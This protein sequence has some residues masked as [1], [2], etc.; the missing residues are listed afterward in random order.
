MP[1]QAEIDR[2]RR[3]AQFLMGQQAPQGGQAGRFYVAPSPFSQ[4]ASA[5]QN[6]AGAFVG[7]QADKQQGELDQQKKDEMAKALMAM[8]TGA[9][10]ETMMASTNPASA[11]SGGNEFLVAQQ[12]ISSGVNPALVSEWL[13][14]Q[15]P[16]DPIKLGQGDRLINPTT[17]EP[18]VSGAP[19]QPKPTDDMREYE[20]AKSQGYP[21][22]FQDYMLEQ[23]KA[24]GTSV[25]VKSEGTIPTGFKAVRDEQGNLIRYEPVPGGPAAIEAE[26][27]ATAAENKN[28][29]ENRK[30]NVVLDEIDRAFAT[31][32]SPSLP[33]TG[34]IGNALKGV[35]GT[36]SHSLANNLTTIKSNIGFDR[37]QAM[38]E[39]SPT[40]GALGNVTVQEIERLEAVLGS[41]L[42]SQR[43]ED[44][45]YNL[46]RLNN[47]YL[48]TV[49]GEGKGPAR[50]ELP[51]LNQGPAQPQQPGMPDFSTMSD[52]ELKRLASGG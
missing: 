19:E 37:L 6:V 29:D 24:G 35:P 2:K 12:A 3:M 18:L 43:E 38:R 9:S 5:G 36:D 34:F 52:D 15:Q 21:G 47:L 44:L 45:R 33:E 42:Q 39:A 16:Q 30:A 23:R 26:Q 27:A 11:P 1:T 49:H 31:L 7:R 8:T 25:N 4:I 22:T 46:A 10:P 28:S 13:K 50:M 32:D 14:R 40:G 17:F 48:D 20:F 41:L 51:D